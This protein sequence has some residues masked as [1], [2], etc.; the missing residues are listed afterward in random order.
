MPLSKNDRVTTLDSHF[1]RLELEYI[2]IVFSTF[3]FQKYTV[4]V[5][6]TYQLITGRVKEVPIALLCQGQLIFV[7]SVY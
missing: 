2:S 1:T 4:F 6:K 3:S 7:S 5:N